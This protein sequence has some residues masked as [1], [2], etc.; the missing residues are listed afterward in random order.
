MQ[1]QH[2]FEQVLRHLQQ[3]TRVFIAA[4][5]V[6]DGDC[7]G[8]ALGLAWV[9]R[10]LGKTVTVTCHDH[11]SSNFDYLPGFAE[12]TPKLPTDEDLLVFVDG[13]ASDRFG[14][15]FDPALF[16]GRAVVEIDHHI[17]NEFFTPIHYVDPQ[18]AS[19]AEIIYRFA[20]ELGVPLDTTIARCLL[21]GIITDTLGLRTASTTVKTL[22]TVTALVQAG[23]SIPEVIDNAFNRVPL[24]TLK[25]HGRILSEATPEGIVLLAEVPLKLMRELGVNANGTGGLVNQLLSVEGTKIAAVLT[26]KD[27]G[28]I[29]VG[30]RARQGVWA[31]GGTSKRLAPSSKVPCPLPEGGSWPKSKSQLVT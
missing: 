15:A 19:T 26:E 11:V 17:T 29:D 24:A 4:H 23:G 22:E 3:S 30:L 20:V 27:N 7:I 14:P 10:K 5:I 12:L 13:S 6:P 31:A 9:L 2:S 21:T 28:K 1:D 16:H 18:A 25:L 8:S